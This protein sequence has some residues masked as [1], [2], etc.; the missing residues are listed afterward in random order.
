MQ[1][2]Q[3]AFC[4]FIDVKTCLSV[5]IMNTVYV[6]KTFPERS[7]HFRQFTYANCRCHVMYA[8]NRL[9]YGIGT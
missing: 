2:H 9:S 8:A 1:F 3:V 7:L 6:N 5:Y 4:Q